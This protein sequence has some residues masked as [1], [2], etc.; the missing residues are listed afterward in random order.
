[1]KEADII[2]CQIQEWYPRFHRV[3]IKTI[4]HPLPEP[5]VD[6][7]LD[8][9]GLFLP[10]TS[11]SDGEDALPSRVRITCPDLQAEDYHHWEEED[12][13]EDEEAQ[14]GPSFPELEKEVKESIQTLGG[15]VFPKLNWSA[16]KDTAWIATNG[17]LK[18]SSFSEIVLL[19]RA[20]DSLVNDLCHAFDSCDDKTADRPLRFY[21]ALRKWYDLRPEME[22]RG[23]VRG[24]LLVGV[25][26]REVT[27]F[28]PG[29]LDEREELE[30]SLFGFFK[31]HISEEFELND[32]TFDC[33][34]TRDGRVKLIDFSPWRAFT[35]PLLFSWEELEKNYDE[36]LEKIKEMK[37]KPYNGA[38][39]S[40]AV[41]E[42][43]GDL[44]F[45]FD[46]EAKNWTQLNLE[47]REEGHKLDFRM[48]DSEG[49][50]QPSLRASSGVPYDYI[51]T[52][53]GSAWDEFLRRADEEVKKQ[54][55]GPAAGA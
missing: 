3:S 32:Y 10:K 54:A 49:R 18:C 25:S 17:T 42:N 28:Y 35:L 40:D 2:R 15:F 8:D 39:S 12:E 37:L 4:L 51:D 47:L 33:Y 27:G 52:G 13:D 53:P 20:S 1:M 50:V 11:S 7:L 24:G 55:N 22:F 46:I 16:P 29:L 41:A 5:F 36:A 38:C 9:G 19:L 48:V 45:D 23:F 44:N 34:V 26:Q 31:E 6:F 21:L 14:A 30:S 43:L